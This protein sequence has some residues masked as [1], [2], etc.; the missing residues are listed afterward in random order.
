MAPMA[1]QFMALGS[2]GQVE[3]DGAVD[4]VAGL[5]RLVELEEGIPEEEVG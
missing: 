1:S 4:W 2:C 3:S 5:R